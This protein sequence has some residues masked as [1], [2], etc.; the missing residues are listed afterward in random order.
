MVSCAMQSTHHDFWCPRFSPT[1]MR[2]LGDSASSVHPLHATTIRS[3]SAPR[4][5][6][7]PTRTSNYES[8]TTVGANLYLRRQ[9]FITSTVQSQV[10]WEARQSLDIG[11]SCWF[12]FRSRFLEFS[13]SHCLMTEFRISALAQ[14]TLEFFKHVASTLLPKC[15]SNAYLT[16][17]CNMLI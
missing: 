10:L 14:L 6:C 1:A 13:D 4:I 11:S 8:V 2:Y 9:W 12:T 17:R 3:Y 16:E 7:H 15:I 5:F